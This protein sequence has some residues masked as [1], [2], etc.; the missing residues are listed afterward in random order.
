[1]YQNEQTISH[2]L[3]VLRKIEKHTNTRNVR[4]YIPLHF[5]PQNNTCTV[6]THT[7]FVTA[8]SAY[9]SISVN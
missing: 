6:R 4:K 9:L 2:I 7:V 3:R 8:S 1:M 5:F